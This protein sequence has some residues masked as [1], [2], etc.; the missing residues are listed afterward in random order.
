MWQDWAIAVIQLAIAISFLPTIFHPTHKPE[1]TTS[2]FTALCIFGFAVVY[3]TLQ[4]WFAMVM[5]AVLAMEWAIVAY[6]RHRLNKRGVV[7][8]P[9]AEI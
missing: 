9:K 4:F 1:I 3:F 2:I 6:Q 5:A 7:E 8:V